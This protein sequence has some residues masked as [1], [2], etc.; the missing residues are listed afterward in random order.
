MHTHQQP[1]TNVDAQTRARTKAMADLYRRD[2]DPVRGA[3][4]DVAPVA[5]DGD[6]GG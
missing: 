6:V 2:A 3:G 1:T 5:G 4:S